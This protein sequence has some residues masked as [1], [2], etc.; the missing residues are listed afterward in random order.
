MHQNFPDSWKFIK[1]IPVH[2][3]N[4]RLD[5]KK[6][7]PDLILYLVSKIPEKVIYGQLY[8]C[9][10][11]NTLFNQNLY[12]YRDGIST[13]T[14]CLQCMIVGYKPHLKVRSVASFYLILALPSIWLTQ[15]CYLRNS[16]SMV[17]ERHH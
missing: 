3:K 12:G 15:V 16:K 17:W 9:F 4:G 13:Q 6:Y 8:D 14:A 2:K 11:K 10:H 1:V 7:R 5:R